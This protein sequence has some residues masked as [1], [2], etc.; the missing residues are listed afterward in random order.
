[1]LDEPN[2]AIEA[3]VPAGILSWLGPAIDEPVPSRRVEAVVLFCDISS[4]TTIANRLVDQGREGLGT[5]RSA[6]NS[7]FDTWITSIDA[8]G[9]TVASFIGDAIVAVWRIEK[10][11]DYVPAIRSA[12]AA[13]EAIIGSGTG[14]LSV[15]GVDVH[16]KCGIGVG[17]FDIMSISL[18]VDQRELVV[19]GEA[20]RRATAACSAG[21][22]ETVEV[23]DGRTESFP[24]GAPARRDL[25]AAV[26]A[27]H[28]PRPIRDRLSA[29]Q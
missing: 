10:T 5:L 28:I 1:M 16:G 11:A 15:A 7:T 19:A 9:G 6:L 26:I 14:S 29:G 23:S 22:P 21:E 2:A 20:L 4:F 25:A 12:R 17:P 3:F 24:S 8:H 27:S 13:A 18:G